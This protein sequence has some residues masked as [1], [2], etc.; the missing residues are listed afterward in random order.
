MNRPR[1]SAIRHVFAIFADAMRWKWVI[2]LLLLP[3]LCS[4][5]LERLLMRNSDARIG[6]EGITHVPQ[7]TLVQV[8]YP[9]STPN[10]E[11]RR[12]MV[13]LPKD[14]ANGQRHYP[15]IYLL[16]GA[17]G[18]QGA[19]TTRG[20][21]HR[22]VDEVY[23]EPDAIPAIIVMPNM[24][25]YDDD[26]DAGQS[27]GRR[28]GAFEALFEIDGT[29][30]SAF[31]QDVVRFVDTHFRTIPDKA[32]RAIAGLSIGGKQAMYISAAYPELFDYVGLFSPMF[33]S[34]IK[35]SEFSS[36]YKNIQEKLD[37]QFVNPPKLYMLA[38]GSG[39]ILYRATRHICNILDRKKYPYVYL[40]SEGGHNWKNW[41]DYL[42]LFLDCVFQEEPASPGQTTP[43]D[44]DN[45]T[46]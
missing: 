20:Q 23:S 41:R 7:G 25:Q 4:C 18:N 27:R 6:L 12:M 1:E 17:R 46:P 24:N 30:E 32:H 21:I 22:I 34:H 35:K 9:V 28:K 29:V 37:A 43:R 11:T 8:S 19:W 45:P 15:V 5:G 14:Y 31:P 2:F 3:G 36:I 16:H 33:G 44:N 39:D 13:Y 40:E 10:M 38:V 42:Y 26:K